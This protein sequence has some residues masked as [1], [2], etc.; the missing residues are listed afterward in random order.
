MKQQQEKVWNFTEF[1]SVVVRAGVNA[2]S[3]FGIRRR[4]AMPAF[5]LS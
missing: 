5:Y 4:I 3:L 2:N 1:R